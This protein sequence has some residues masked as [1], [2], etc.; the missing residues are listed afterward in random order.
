M[1]ILLNFLFIQR[2]VHAIGSHSLHTRFLT[3]EPYCETNIIYSDA[4]S[5]NCTGNAFQDGESCA[6]QCKE[7]VTL[8]CNCLSNVLSFLLISNEE[9]CFWESDR[10]CEVS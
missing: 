5:E 1:R 3:A 7:A 6:A 8:T 10:A 2:V 9:G 4:T